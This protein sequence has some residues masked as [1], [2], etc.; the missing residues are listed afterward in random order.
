MSS[1]LGNT[2]V[3]VSVIGSLL[4]AL[5]IGTAQVP[6]DYEKEFDFSNGTGASQADE[7]FLDHR[8]LAASTSENL[9]LNTGTLKDAFGNSVALTKLK[10]LVIR[11]DPGNTNDVVIGAAGSN[12]ITSIMG[13]TGTANVKPGG[14]VVFVAPDVNG[15]AI[16]PA[17]AMV[18]KVANSGAGTQVIYDIIAIGL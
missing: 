1:A 2:A 14:I 11:A 15:Y 12:P 10:A 7:V 3:K 9:D 6:I 13:A 4:S 17:T 5:G 8:T 16:T 18:L